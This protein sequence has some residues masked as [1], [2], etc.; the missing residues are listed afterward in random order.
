MAHASEERSTV[1]AI[2]QGAVLGPLPAKA[3]QVFAQLD[4]E[5]PAKA[6]APYNTAFSL[7]LRGEK[8]PSLVTVMYNR[9]S[10]HVDT[11]MIQVSGQGC[12]WLDRH[13]VLA[14]VVQTFISR[15]GRVDFAFDFASGLRP[16]AAFTT[17]RRTSVLRSNTGETVY[18]GSV[19]SDRYL[20]VYRYNPPHPRADRLRFEF[21]FKSKAQAKAA[22]ETWLYRY[23]DFAS[24]ARAFGVVAAEEL[25][26]EGEGED[27]AQVGRNPSSSEASSTLWLITAAAPAF[28]KLCQSGAIADP[29]AFISQ[30]FLEGLGLDE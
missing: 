24:F 18:A 22:L 10:Q 2:L 17:D 1:A 20:R 8:L 23:T 15:I 21:V 29:M 30:Y 11:L 27:L 7:G 13:N 3:A 25:K 14:D 19:K 6:L 16:E 12:Q 26:I 28:R 4:S 5:A 9:S